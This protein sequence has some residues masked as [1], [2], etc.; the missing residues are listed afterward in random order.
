MPTEDWPELEACEELF[1]LA[2]EGVFR[3]ARAGT[4]VEGVLDPA[5]FRVTN[6]DG[7]KLSGAR[8]DRTTGAAAYQD[9]LKR[10]QKQNPDVLPPDGT[11][12][13]PVE[14]AH[15][16]GLRCV[17]DEPC[18]ADLPPAHTYIDHRQPDLNG[19]SKAAKNRREDMR[20][21]LAVNAVL[22]Y[23]PIT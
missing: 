16:I 17:Y 23:K 7:G 9:R 15:E 8:S 1:E 2:G 5:A 19:N 13:V 3:V 12:L 4:F 21:Q 20:Q 22:K 18:D 11:W 10:T 14:V 6:S